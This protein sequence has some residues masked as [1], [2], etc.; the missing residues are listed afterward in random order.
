MQGVEINIENLESHIL[1]LKAKQEMHWNG[2]NVAELGTESKGKVWEA[3][4]DY[5]QSSDEITQKLDELY[6]TMNI[7]L[8]CLK[9]GIVEADEYAAEMIKSGYMKQLP[10][11]NRESAN[12]NTMQSIEALE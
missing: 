5:K 8:E 11:E 4:C 2:R 3:L 10:Q 7:F 9:D 6:G 1:E 12:I